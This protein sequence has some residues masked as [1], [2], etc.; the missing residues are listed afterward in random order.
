MADTV[1]AAPAAAP[2]TVT[3]PPEVTLVR[4]RPLQVVLVGA[5]GTGAR[6]GPDI[7]RLLGRGDRLLVV[8]PDTVEERNLIRQHFIRA[9]IGRF[10]AEVVAGRATAAATPGVEVEPMIMA[11]T[12][13][14]QIPNRVLERHGTAIPTLWVGAV[15]NRTC[16][17]MAAT[18]FD[19][20]HTGLWL[21]AG[22]D[23][24][25]G[26]VGMMGRWQIEEVSDP[27]LGKEAPAA[28]LLAACRRR[29]TQGM[30]ERAYP[31]EYYQLTCLPWLVVNTLREI[32]PQVL[33]PSKEEEAKTP[34]CEIRLDTQ[35][36][37][38]NVMAYACVVNLISRVLDGLPIATGA[39]F[40]STMNTM[41][42]KPWTGLRHTP[43]TQLVQGSVA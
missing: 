13:L 18:A 25:G 15:D 35:S 32:T 12:D 26:Q 29:I 3:L 36:L 8:D 30:A 1:T 21:D 28:K 40:F 42:A 22:N 16:R 2:P 27:T 41:Q 33:Q 19:A 10:K 5:G 9:D 38:A 39:A 34:D 20:G 6:L 37:A 31:P 23:L 17:K 43:G 24:R 14:G 7:A 4:Y 11:L